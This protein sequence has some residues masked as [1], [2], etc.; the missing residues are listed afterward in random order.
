MKPMN[1]DDLMEFGNRIPVSATVEV[2]FNGQWYPLDPSRIRAHIPA[3]IILPE[4]VGEEAS[5]RS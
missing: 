5:C 3:I 2:E 4:E 1:G